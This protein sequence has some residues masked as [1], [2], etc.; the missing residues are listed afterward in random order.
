MPNQTVDPG[1]AEL[2]RATSIY[3]EVGQAKPVT[4]E[5]L[6]GEVDQPYGVQKKDV[7]TS[8]YSGYQPYDD[9]RITRPTYGSQPYSRGAVAA[10]GFAKQPTME[11]VEFEA[12]AAYKAPEYEPPERDP[13]LEKRLRQEYMAPG[14]R[15]VRR[16]T[17]QAIISSKSLDNPNARSLFIQKALEG[18]GS[19]VSQIAGTAGKEA[20][21]EAEAR[22]QDDLS[23]Y[24]TAWGSLRD[25]SKTRYD[26][27]W[28]QAIMKYQEDQWAREKGV[29]LE[30][31]NPMANV[32]PQDYNKRFR[33]L[34]G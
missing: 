16:S 2:Q 20:R 11:R 10:S 32:A 25:E 9:N 30:S 19:A 18:V 5:S 3:E 27:E 1:L 28:Q 15:Q 33:E 21:A 6:Y 4:Y 8:G 17:Q 14:M 31:A 13:M 26:A 12:P 29:E 24:H 34:Y 22:Y 7:R 23:K